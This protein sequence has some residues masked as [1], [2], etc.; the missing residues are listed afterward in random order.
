[1]SRPIV[2][3]VCMIGSLESWGLNSTHIHGTRLPVEEP[4]A[5]SEANITYYTD[6]ICE[7][8]LTSKGPAVALGQCASKTGKCA[9]VMT[10][11]VAPPNIICLSRLC[12]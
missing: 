12:V 9:F 2:V 8:T 1:M 6:M 5:A 3:I 4:S 7:S 11:C 10:C